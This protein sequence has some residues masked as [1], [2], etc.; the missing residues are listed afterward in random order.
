LHG[1]LQDLQDRGYLE[2]IIKQKMRFCQLEHCNNKP[3]NRYYK[4]I[5]SLFNKKLFIDITWSRRKNK[6]LSNN[7]FFD[8]LEH[9]KN[10]K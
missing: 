1:E 6:R 10:I 7:N 2:T 9:N 8:G 4:K 3:A 5:Y